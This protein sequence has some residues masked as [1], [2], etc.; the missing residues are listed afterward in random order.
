MANF[1]A[2]SPLLVP[3]AKAHRSRVAF[4]GA[5]KRSSPC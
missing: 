5:L 2:N 1:A 4:F 3:S